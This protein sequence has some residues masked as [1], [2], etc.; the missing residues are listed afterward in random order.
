MEPVYIVLLVM[1]I[2]FVIFL[3]FFLAFIKRL[4]K[5]NY[6]KSINLKTEVNS[7]E[8][9][10]IIGGKEN[11]KN[12]YATFNHIHFYLISIDQVQI[13]MFKLRK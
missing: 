13:S 9:I 7:E 4:L 2:I 1:L 5:I 12:L 10:T 3:I 6:D 8:L 11:I